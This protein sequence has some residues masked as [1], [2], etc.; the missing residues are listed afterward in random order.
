VCDRAGHTRTMRPATAS[1][2]LEL[3]AF[4]FIGREKDYGGLHLAIAPATA[5]PLCALLSELP[6]RPAGRSLR[7][8][9]RAVPVEVP[10]RIVSRL[11]YRAIAS[12]EIRL[13]DDAPV[14][15]ETAEG[16]ARVALPASD[17]AALASA[18]RAAGTG[19][20]D[21]CVASE[22]GAWTDRVWVWP[23]SA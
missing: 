5:E 22:S 17:L 18:V 12:V 21:L 15:V 6:R 3:I 20:G 13:R 16:R 8:R 23:L 9:G 10:A 14:A 1:G 19:V 7:L 2:R 4:F 11:R